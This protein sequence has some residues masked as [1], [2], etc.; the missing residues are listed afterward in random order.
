MTQTRDTP[1]SALALAHVVY[2]L[3]T[4]AILVGLFGSGSVIGSFVGSAPSIIA[5]IL[6]YATR[7]D[8]RGTWLE[9]HYG[10]QIRTFWYALAWVVFGT[11]VALTWVAWMPTA[12]F[13]DRA[14]VALGIFFG[15]TLWLIYR[16]GAG[17]MRLSRH[18]AMPV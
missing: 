1:S 6:N 15:L 12:D 2:A 18:S 7:G 10:W 17:W 8:A 16:I 3:H 11:L 13:L 5:V 9:S 14:L 4:A